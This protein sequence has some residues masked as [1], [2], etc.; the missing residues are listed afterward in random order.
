RYGRPPGAART[1]PVSFVVEGH[2]SHAVTRRLADEGLFVSSGDFYASTVVERL[3]QAEHGLI[4][5][6]CACY[7]STDEIDRLLYAVR[8]L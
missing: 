8:R 3:G 6:G 5:V 4:R 7:T 2:G 1:P